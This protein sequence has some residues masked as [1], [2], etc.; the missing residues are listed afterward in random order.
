[1]LII[2]ED[3]MLYSANIIKYSCG[4]KRHLHLWKVKFLFLELFAC[5]YYHSVGVRGSKTVTCMCIHILYILH[6]KFISM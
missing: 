6:K 5:K 3:T 4:K 2:L 1:M